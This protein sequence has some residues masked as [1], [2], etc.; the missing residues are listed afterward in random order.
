MDIGFPSYAFGLS[1]SI[2]GAEQL[3]ELLVFASAIVLPHFVFSGIF[4]APWTGTIPRGVGGAATC[5][6]PLD[7]SVVG[8][9]RLKPVM[10]KPAG[11][12]TGAA[13]LLSPSVAWLSPFVDRGAARLA[14][15]QNV[16]CRGRLLLTTSTTG[17]Y[18]GP[19]V[20]CC[21]GCRSCS[22]LDCSSGAPRGS[23]LELWRAC[24]HLCAF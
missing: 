24:W 18:S 11:N 1:F 14:T 19:G 15:N 4:A 21:T 3:G 22:L 5:D 7:R 20:C 12:A 8:A 10:T 17:R 23:P 2:I 6:A 9:V 16:S 13:S